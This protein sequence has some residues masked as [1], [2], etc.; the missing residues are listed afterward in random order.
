LLQV[1][2][3]V[4]WAWTITAC[5]L[6]AWLLLRWVRAGRRDPLSSA[7]VRPNRLHDEAVLV[8]VAAYLIA[9]GLL[10]ALVQW[11]WGTTDVPLAGLVIGNG[12]QL[13]GLFAC[14]AI[15]SARFDGG[16]RSFLLG[17]RRGHNVWPRPT[18]ITAIIAIAFCP[19]I[20]EWT[21]H[22]VHLVAPGYEFPTHPTMTALRSGDQPTWLVAALW[23]GAVVIAPA[24][25]ECFF[26]GLLQ[27][28]F[29]NVFRG[30]WAAILTA[31][32]AFGL[33]HISQPHA[34][35]ALTFLAILLGCL[36]ERTGSILPA[37][38]VHAMFN[39]K[40]L[41]WDAVGT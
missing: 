13:A 20:G 37:I 27:T 18:L 3:A 31:S 1:L 6:V 21:I 28:Y 32:V 39:L 40:T 25:E 30:R 10:T 19:L 29:A 12:A 22:A 17:P 26:R 14:L 34:L 36:Y 2:Q 8:P 24:A 11:R 33:V 4:D 35:V 7:P 15:A 9:A 23:I 41:V 5:L 16:V 38:A